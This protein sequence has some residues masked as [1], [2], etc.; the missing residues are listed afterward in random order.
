MHRTKQESKGRETNYENCFQEL[1]TLKKTERSQSDAIKVIGTTTG[2]EEAVKVISKGMREC[3]MQLQPS[4]AKNFE[5]SLNES[6]DKTVNHRNT[7]RGGGEQGK[8]IDYDDDKLILAL[9]NKIKRYKIRVHNEYNFDTELELYLEPLGKIFSKSNN[10][11]PFELTFETQKRFLDAGSKA[12]ILILA[13]ETGIGKTLFCRHLQR[14]LLSEW[15]SPSQEENER[16]WV[17]IFIDLSSMVYSEVEKGN[18]LS[19]ILHQQLSLTESE[20]K[21]LQQSE[22]NPLL[23]KFL[24]IFDGFDTFFE[25][26]NKSLNTDECIRN[27]FCKLIGLEPFLENAKIILACRTATLADDSC[28]DAIFGPLGESTEKVS[29][30]LL[31]KFVLEPFND[32]QIS[33][34]LKL[35]TVSNLRQNIEK[36][37]NDHPEFSESWKLMR[38]Y[39]TLIDSYGARELARTPLNLFI[40]VQTLQLPYQKNEQEKRN[41]DG[42]HMRPQKIKSESNI[43]E[44]RSHKNDQKIKQLTTYQLYDR[45]ANQLIDRTIEKI[46]L[47]LSQNEKYQEGPDFLKQKLK[48][49]LQNLALQF[50]N[51][52][53][54]TDEEEK[55]QKEQ[56]LSDNHSLLVHCPLL[57]FDKIVVGKPMAFLHSSFKDYFVVTKIVD[58]IKNHY[59]ETAYC[60]D[61]MLLNQKL[62]TNDSRSLPILRFLIDAVTSEIISAV[63]MLQ[64]IQKSRSSDAI[65]QKK[66]HNQGKE[67][68]VRPL[69][70]LKEIRVEE[71]IGLNPREIEFQSKSNKCHHFSIAAANAITILNASGHDFSKMNFSEI[72]IPGA[73]LSH[74]IFEGT[75]FTGADLRGVDFTDAWLKD[76]KFVEANMERVQFGALLDLKLDKEVYSIA[77]S[78][79]GNYMVVGT[80]GD[81]IVFKEPFLKKFKVFK[82][83]IGDINSCSFSTDGKCILSGGEDGTIRIWDFESGECLRLLK[84]GSTSV[85]GCEFSQDGR[86]F[87][88]HDANEIVRTWKLLK[89]EWSILFQKDLKQLTNC[90]FVPKGNG[91]IF[92]ATRYSLKLFHS[93]H[94]KYLFEYKTPDEY[95]A[96]TMSKFH[97]DG[98]QVALGTTNGGIHV[99]DYVR[100]C[101]IK[102]L[103]CPN[104]KEYLYIDQVVDISFSSCGTNL[105]SADMINLKIED[106]ADGNHL[107][108]FLGGRI[109]QIAVNP[110]IQMQGVKVSVNSFTKSIA[111]EV[112]ERVNFSMIKGTNSKGLELSGANIDGSLRLSEENIM[113]FD[114][115]GDYQGFGTENIQKMILNTKGPGLE[116]ITTIDLKNREINARGASVLGRNQNWCNLRKLDLS[117]NEIS[118][119]GAVEIAKNKSWTNLQELSL[120]S[121]KIFDRALVTIS[122]NTSWGNLRKLHLKS[123]RISSLGAATLGTN[124]IW[125]NLEELD[126]SQN[127]IGDDG[128]IAISHNDTWKDLKKLNLSSNEVDNNGARALSANLTWTYLEELNLSDNRIGD[129]GAIEIGQNKVWTNLKLLSLES[130]KIGDPGLTGIAK[131]VSWTSLEEL[132]LFGNYIGQKLSDKW[133]MKNNWPKIKMI[134]IN[135][136]NEN[137]RNWLIDIDSKVKSQINLESQD[138][139]YL[140]AAIIERAVLWS[141]LEKLLLSGNQI[142][143][144]GAVA[145]GSNTSWNKLKTLDLGNNRI[146]DEG[147]TAVGLNT[148]WINLEIL[149]L[150]EN[151]IGDKGGAVVGNNATWSKLRMLSFVKNRIGDETAV[152]IA[153]NTTWTKLEGLWLNWNAIGNKGASA[154]GNNTIW[155][156]LKTISLIANRL[157]DEGAISIG[158][159][160]T[161]INLEELYFQE[162]E[163]GDN[164]ASAIASNTAWGKLKYL[165]IGEMKLGEQGAI[166]IGS[167]K[168]WDNLEELGLRGN[169]IGS[170]GASMIG[171]NTSWHKLI[172]LSLDRNRIGNEGSISIGSNTT[173]QNLR[174]LWLQENEIGDAGAVAIGTNS[175]WS[176]LRW[177]ILMRNRIGDEGA[178][179]I[180]TNTNWVNLE[181]LWLSENEIGNRGAAAIGNNTTW[182]KLK[183]LSL[184]KNRIGDEGAIAIGSNVTWVKLRELWLCRNEIS[185]KG[186]KAIAMNSTWSD[187]TKLSLAMNKI[188]VEGMTALGQNTVWTSLEE[189][190]IYDNYYKND[191]SIFQAFTNENW[192][193]LSKLIH[194]INPALKVLLDSTRNQIVTEVCLSSKGLTDEDAIIIVN[195]LTATIEALSLSQNNIGDEGADYIASNNDWKHLRKLDLSS[196]KISEGGA[197]AIGKVS[198]W[199]HLQEL[200]LSHNTIG[201]SGTIAIERNYT[202]RNLTKI[203]LSANALSDEAAIVIGTSMRWPNLEEL[204]LNENEIGDEGAMVIGENIFWRK[205]VK[206]EIHSNLNITKAGKKALKMNHIFGSFVLV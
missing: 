63:A 42:S 141:G 36:D 8:N 93:T 132:Y 95:T 13:G 91:L 114:Q 3:K 175:I 195:T 138:V 81:L 104:K 185:D 98:R 190:F 202:L 51:Y 137:I 152:A 123:N 65:S 130:N 103:Q 151:Q 2:S 77:Y 14:T 4:V 128:A 131:N 113:L 187:L 117:M 35:Y 99:L 59:N 57:K 56:E 71:E 22:S 129:K 204:Y 19:E 64:F 5:S 46:L 183:L 43:E 31:L 181:E 27:N 162:N 82:G 164:G 61:D 109:R 148:V 169:K 101:L 170:K 186:A 201:D 55:L 92:L 127:E 194:S 67:T 86:Q 122:A 180:G 33:S 145:I 143:D 45:F 76:T 134:I 110:I 69:N 44:Q 21:F 47:S 155:T 158:A 200:N 1:L 106:I 38:K 197:E 25:E 72:Q 16:I 75:N 199:I 142:G 140:D 52:S 28:R 9:F 157:Q 154:L 191:E 62:L 139:G 83:H 89:D 10:R 174:E 29:P 85:I 120:A 121:N 149:D 107:I 34:Y 173:W 124:S 73:N 12:K 163:I 172:T 166:S 206:I 192:E 66:L 30:N 58:E 84:G 49:Q 39:E 177:L 125:K 205:L 70:S 7:L 118:D 147:A 18:V 96:F 40:L 41:P 179:A 20:I 111:R 150:S 136:K 48:V 161:W 102:T 184:Y 50:S 105:I 146:G 176:Q 100:G 133:E 97:D 135:A 53:Q 108:K 6:D 32:N 160:T 15:D 178:M 196:N 165:N 11:E 126:L 153:L 171:N 188:G 167:N 203:D 80:R 54:R 115:K 26:M 17:P 68:D 23:P 159:N 182:K 90:G 189:F 88:L 168:T 116:N 79:D 94:Q 37:Q 60:S 193:Y 198:G 156:K 78:P 74:G 119:D 112:L 144:K 24:F 87:I